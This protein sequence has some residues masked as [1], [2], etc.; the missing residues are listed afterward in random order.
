M[1]RIEPGLRV[2]ELGSSPFSTLSH[3]VALDKCLGWIF[4]EADT[5]KGV[6]EQAVC[7]EGEGNT[8]RGVGE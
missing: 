7:L 2:R 3:C 4:P 6:Q 1:R 8:G 5:K